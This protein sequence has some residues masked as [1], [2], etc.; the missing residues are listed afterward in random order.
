MRRETEA[1]TVVVGSV[2]RAQRSVRCDHGSREGGAM[3]DTTVPGSSAELDVGWM[4]SALRKGEGAGLLDSGTD[5]IGAT[6]IP[7]QSAVNLM[8]ELV[9][10]E[11]QWSTDKPGLP[12]SLVA[13]LPSPS[14]DNHALC[15][16]MGYYEA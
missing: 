1:R 4:A 11:L 8:G 9:R 6:F 7:I 12:S 15:L 13:K 10:C 14:P 3:T 16:A 2:M 5:L